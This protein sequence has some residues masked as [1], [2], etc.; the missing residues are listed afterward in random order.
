[1]SKIKEAMLKLKQ[2]ETSVNFGIV[3]HNTNVVVDL[4]IKAYESNLPTS[5][6]VW[7]IVNKETFSAIDVMDKLEL[8]RKEKVKKYEWFKEMGYLGGGKVKVI[9]LSKLTEE[10]AKKT[11]EDFDK[12]QKREVEE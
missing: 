11:F 1:M 5:I 4:C 7:D 10:E 6:E 3:G 9:H 2:D 8:L 12:W